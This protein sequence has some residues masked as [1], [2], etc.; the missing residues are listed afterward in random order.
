[1]KIKSNQKDQRTPN[2]HAICT[3]ARLSNPSHLRTFSRIVIQ[4]MNS[5]ATA[6]HY[7]NSLFQTQSHGVIHTRLKLQKMWLQTWGIWLPE[8]IWSQS[9]NPKKS[10][11]I[12]LVLC[13]F[14]SRTVQKYLQIEAVNFYLTTIGGLQ[15]LGRSSSMCNRKALSRSESRLSR[16][17]RMS[18]ETKY[19][20]LLMQTIVKS[21]EFLFLIS[22]HQ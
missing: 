4:P 1:M 9:Q 3:W 13:T 6:D 16:K 18:W 17:S 8:T 11:T 12:P 5:H 10:I 19:H 2:W 22:S 20:R 21:S 7:P 15:V 14:R